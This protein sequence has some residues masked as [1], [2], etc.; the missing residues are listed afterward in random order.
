MTGIQVMLNETQSKELQKYI[1]DITSEAVRN[2][3][4]D[5]GADKDFLNQRE[6]S[7]WVGVSVNTL[8]TYIREGLPIIIM[9]GR[10]FYSKK[11]VSKF[12]LARQKGGLDA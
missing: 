2:A 6:M 1:F 10:N 3:I 12:L 11:E 9:G 5:V 7:D 8:K 4:Q